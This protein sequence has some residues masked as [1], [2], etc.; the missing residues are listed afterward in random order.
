[1]WFIKGGILVLSDSFFPLHAFSVGVL[2]FNVP[3]SKYIQFPREAKKKKK[4]HT[5]SLIPPP[6]QP[7]ALIA[8][9]DEREYLI[10]KD[11]K[12]KKSLRPWAEH[13][14]RPRHA[15]FSLSLARCAH[16]GGSRTYSSIL[17]SFVCERMKLVRDCGDILKGWSPL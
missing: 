5:Y 4:K 7:E 3:I 11:E 10:L 12:N 14:G 13:P 15:A 2:F 16:T 1:M 6:S 9:K 8:P 17:F